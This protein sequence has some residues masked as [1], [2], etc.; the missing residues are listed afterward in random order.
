M[1]QLRALWHRVRGVFAGRRAEQELSAELESHLQDHTDDNL[2]AGM[3]PAEARRQALVALGGVESTKEAVR[4]RRGLPSV[5]SLVRDLRYGARTL[6]RS[7]GF[8]FAGILILGLGVGVNSAIF[9]VVNAVVLQPLPFK[10]ADRIVR[11]RHTPPQATFPGMKTF[12]LSPANFLDWQTESTSF[13]AMALYTSRRPVLTGQ[14]EA[15]AVNSG[16]VP[17]SFLQSSACS[18][19]SGARSRRPTKPKE[20]RVSRFWPNCSGGRASAPMQG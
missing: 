15:A 13:A 20:P 5:E 10:D 7:P 9:T 12:A 4:E 1:R 19:S 8:A 2:R 11:V 6:F 17:A 18:R 16:R 14:G 3:S